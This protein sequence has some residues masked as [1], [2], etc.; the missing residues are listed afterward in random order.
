MER[1]PDLPSRWNGGGATT[2][3]ERGNRW[4]GAKGKIC[5][6]NGGKNIKIGKVRNKLP[7]LVLTICG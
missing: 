4:K 7:H 6:S 1:S 2:E 5:V 3:K